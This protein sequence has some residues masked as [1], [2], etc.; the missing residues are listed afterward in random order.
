MSQKIC[1]ESRN[2]RM[3]L[4]NLVREGT[5]LRENNLRVIFFSN[6][7]YCTRSWCPRM[8]RIHYTVLLL[9]DKKPRGVEYQFVWL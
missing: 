5:K 4:Q 8:C 7:T 3:R 1:A 9:L 2:A 6:S